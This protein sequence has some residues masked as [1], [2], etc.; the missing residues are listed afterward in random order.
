LYPS[1]ITQR[2][3]A[4]W[5]EEFADTQLADA[6]IWRLFYQIVIKRHVFG[7]T[8]D[9]SIVQQAHE[10]HIPSALDY[11]ESQLPADGFL[12]GELSIADISIAC[13][14]R[15]AA[16]VRFAV[17]AQRWPR[18]A[19]FVERVLSLEPFRKLAHFEDAVLRIPLAE[20]RAAL[21]G[22]GAPLM[23]KSLSSDRPRHGLPRS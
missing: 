11:L 14:F 3:K 4:R 19:A 22:A 8:T 6:L 15:T 16:F 18:T 20:Q 10:V 2:A 9:E 1:D 21:T 5:L 12:F 17:D 23:A 7:E 13:Y